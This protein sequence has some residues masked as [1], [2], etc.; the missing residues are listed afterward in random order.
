MGHF[1]PLTKQQGARN[2]PSKQEGEVSVERMG[3]EAAGHLTKKQDAR[4][5]KGGTSPRFGGNGGKGVNKY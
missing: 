4:R 2:S 5:S 3:N 1:H